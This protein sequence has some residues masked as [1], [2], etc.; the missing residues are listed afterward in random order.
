ML[1][2]IFMLRLETILRA[3]KDSTLAGNT[4]TSTSSDIRFVPIRLLAISVGDRRKSADKY[5]EEGSCGR[6]SGDE[7]LRS[8][9]GGERR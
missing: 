9:L 4:P 3:S 2:E 1:A 6:T 7:P 5:L 8:D